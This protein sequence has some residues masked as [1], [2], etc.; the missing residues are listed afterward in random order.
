MPVILTKEA[1][2]DCINQMRAYLKRW[3]LSIHPPFSLSVGIRGRTP[4]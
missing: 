2:V 1:S 4:I 3:R